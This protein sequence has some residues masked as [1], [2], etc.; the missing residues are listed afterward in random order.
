[1]TCLKNF[2][3]LRIFPLIICVFPWVSSPIDAGQN[4]DEVTVLYLHGLNVLKNEKR[5][6]MDCHLWTVE[7]CNGNNDS[8]QLL[9]SLE[10]SKLTE[11][12][13]F[14]RMILHLI[15]ENL[16][17]QEELLVSWKDSICIAVGIGNKNVELLPI[18][19]ED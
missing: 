19:W 1:M 18:L 4:P 10:T 12:G 13:L 5:L 15:L 3:L 2:F 9:S 11:G 8:W 14:W 7:R 16:K 17:L 6:I